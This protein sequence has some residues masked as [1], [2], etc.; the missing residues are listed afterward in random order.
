[1]KS[2]IKMADENASCTFRLTRDLVFISHWVANGIH[3]ARL[4]NIQLL[5]NLKRF[6]NDVITMLIHVARSV[7]LGAMAICADT[8]RT[9]IWKLQDGSRSIPRI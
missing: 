4:W 9:S 3:T 7:K 5:D 8:W 6:D 2:K 1:M